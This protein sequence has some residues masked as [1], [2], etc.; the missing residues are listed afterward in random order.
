MN[1]FYV[2]LVVLFT[3]IIAIW[4]QERNPSVTDTV[5]V[6]D[7]LYRE[8]QFYFGVTYNLITAVPT[9]VSIR[10]FSGGTRFGFVRDMPVNKRRNIAFGVGLG[11]GFN[12]YGNTLSISET[13]N[14]Q[15]QYAVLSE[16]VSFESNRFSTAHIEVPLEFRWRSS[17]VSNYKF[18][19]VHAGAVVSYSYW[20]R[21]TFVQDGT[22]FKTRN[23]NEF[24][25]IQLEATLLFGYNTFNF[26]AAYGITPFFDNSAKTTVEQVDFKPLKL[27]IL[28]YF[29]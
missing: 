9:G 29:L 2:L 21:A 6:I 17:T 1:R 3:P 20:N 22:R 8:D 26:Y 4:S 25:P 5:A 24:N 16:E 14:G 13:A 27:G 10:G 12:R 19:R 7:S 11:L 23:V 28:F 15:T 18:Y